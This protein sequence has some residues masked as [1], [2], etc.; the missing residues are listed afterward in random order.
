MRCKF[1]VLT[2]QRCAG[3]VFGWL[4]E[5]NISPVSR[6][7]ATRS[8]SPRSCLSR[9][10]FSLLRNSLFFGPMLA[11]RYTSRRFGSLDDENLR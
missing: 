1:A 4:W 5:Q 8:R 11:G 7:Q 2:L 6:W 9:R 10:Q 3:S